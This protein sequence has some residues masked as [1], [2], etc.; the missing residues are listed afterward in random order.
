MAAFPNYSP[1]PGAS[2]ARQPRIRSV[3]FGDGYEQRGQDGINA[4]HQK[5]SLTWSGRSVTDATAIDTFLATQGGVTSFTW[6]PPGGTSSN[7]L[8]KSWNLTRDSYASCTVTAV[9]EE[10]F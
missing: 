8:C 5:W 3:R 9:F 7:W 6:T 1:D 4:N 2:M 10:V